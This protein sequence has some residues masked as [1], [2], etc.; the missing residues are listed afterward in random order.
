[1]DVF[2]EQGEERHSQ[3]IVHYRT[4][5]SSS[6]HLTNNVADVYLGLDSSSLE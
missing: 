2:G 1:M 4:M 6:E 3:P 5:W